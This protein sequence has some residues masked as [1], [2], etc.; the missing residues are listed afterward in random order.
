MQANSKMI[1]LMNN[2]LIYEESNASILLNKLL[3]LLKPTLKNVHGCLVIDNNNEIESENVNFERILKIH[4]DK[5]GYEASVNEVRINDFI[6]GNNINFRNVLMLGFDVLDSWSNL[7]KKEYPQKKFCLMISCQNEF[8]T[9][10]FHQ[11]REGES[12]WLLD[13]LEK[14]DSAIAVETI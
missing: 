8:V 5:T 1:T 11:V 13:D 10:R 14:Y 3:K 4:G 9:L 7:L 2:K 12:R 6:C